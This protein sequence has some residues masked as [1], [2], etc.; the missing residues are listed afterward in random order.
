MCVP[1]GFNYPIDSMNSEEKITM[2]IIEN[3]LSFKVMIGNTIISYSCII[4]KTGE[5]W[6]EVAGELAQEGLRPTTPDQE[7]LQELLQSYEERAEDVIKQ[8]HELMDS[9][10]RDDLDEEYQF[11]EKLRD[12]Q[13]SN[14]KALEK[15]H[16]LL[17]RTSNI[18]HLKVHEW[19][20]DR[21]FKLNY[22]MLLGGK[23][24]TTS[25]H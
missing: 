18:K 2:C 22:V 10:H 3:Y 12:A 9:Q 16:S 14:E 13:Y 25:I 17:L 19:K 4:F 5:V 11:Y 20:S 23:R 6:Y 8:Q 24:E 15:R 21:C 7:D 1:L